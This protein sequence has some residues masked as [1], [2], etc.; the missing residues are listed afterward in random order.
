MKNPEN[1]R[2]KADSNGNE[3]WISGH[4]PNNIDYAK[5]VAFLYF[6]RRINVS[7]EFK[8]IQESSDLVDITFSC[9][10]KQFGAHKLVLFACSPYFRE[11]LKVRLTVTIDS[12]VWLLDC[13]RNFNCYPFSFKL[14][15]SMLTS[16]IF[17]QWRQR[18][19]FAC[20]SRL[21]VHGWSAHQ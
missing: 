11:I 6:F 19:G 21:Y 16:G 4:Q 12:T 8:K 9:D 18:W 10:G 5:I 20:N 2:F 17:H 7:S 14:E 1:S 3:V 13:L 15:K